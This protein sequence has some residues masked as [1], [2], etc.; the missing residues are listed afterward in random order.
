MSNI[1]MDQLAGRVALD[2]CESPKLDIVNF[3]LHPIT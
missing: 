2:I 3:R 1:N